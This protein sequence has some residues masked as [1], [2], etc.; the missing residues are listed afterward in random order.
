[1]QAELRFDR[2]FLPLSVP[3]GLGPAS[4][5][6]RVDAGNLHVKMGWAFTADI[7][8]AAIKKAEVSNARVFSAGV[9][10][11]GSRWLVNGSRKGLVALTIDPPARAKAVWRKSVTVGTLVV[12]VT[13]PEAFVAA[14]TA[15]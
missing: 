13:D 3:L 2:W 5:E 4:S 10:F 14:C 11:F 7:P 9:H 1:M 8:L 15:K 6:L 12:S